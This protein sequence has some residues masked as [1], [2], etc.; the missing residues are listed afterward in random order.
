[1]AWLCEHYNGSNNATVASK[2]QQER[3]VHEIAHGSLLMLT[4]GPS[5]MHWYRTCSCCAMVLMMVAVSAG[6]K[7]PAN[8]P[9]E[10]STSQQ[11]P[12]S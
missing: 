1:V 2:Y 3:I 9:T 5:Y 4:G 11:P 8:N 6:E 7:A 12:L 10:L